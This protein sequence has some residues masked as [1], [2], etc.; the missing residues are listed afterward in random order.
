[1]IDLPDAMIYSGTDDWD[2]WGHKEYF[3]RHKNEEG[4]VSNAKY[5][6]FCAKNYG[7]GRRAENY[8][9]THHHYGD[10]N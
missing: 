8:I 3:C 6:E 9:N 2:N 1:M 7:F 10:S 5:M 4:L